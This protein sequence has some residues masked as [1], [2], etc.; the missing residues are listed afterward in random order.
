M[1]EE[2]EKRSGSR[3][4]GRPTGSS[5]GGASRGSG[6][7]A[8]GPRWVDAVALLAALGLHA[9][10]PLAPTPRAVEREPPRA[11]APELELELDVDLGSNDQRRAEPDMAEATKLEAAKARPLM[12][13]LEPPKPEV[14]KPEAPKPEP[15]PEPSKREA[16]SANVEQ[17][18]SAEAEA[19]KLAA[20]DD[21]AP[22]L[23]TLPSDDARD[24]DVAPPLPT[25]PRAAPEPA[26]PTLARSEPARV[27]PPEPPRAAPP[28]PPPPARAEPPRAVPAALTPPRAPAP[29]P[30][31]AAE[32]AP[33]PASPPAPPPPP[34][35]PAPP[36]AP[37]PPPPAPPPSPAPTPAAPPGP[38]AARL[39][40]GPA[41]APGVSPGASTAP[42]PEGPSRPGPGPSDGPTRPDGGFSPLAPLPVPGLGGPLWGLPGVLPS[43]RPPPAPTEPT[44]R[45]VDP[46]AATKALGSTLS[47]RDG[48][49]GLDVPGASVAASALTDAVRGSDL[50][51]E[52][53]AT[54][55]VK[56]DASGRVESIKVLGTTAGDAQ[57]WAAVVASAKA[58][59]EGRAL[60]MGPR[61]EAATVVVKVESSMR[62]PAGSR[63]AGVVQPVCANE[64]IEQIEALLKTP[65]AVAG[66]GRG[67]DETGTNPAGPTA[68]A[69][70]RAEE[71]K[72]KF[73]I[74]IGVR[75][76]GDLSNIG[77]RASKVVKNDVSI[78][79]AGEVALPE[80][81]V[82]PVDT[83]PRWLP[84]DPTKTRPDLPGKKPWWQKKKKKKK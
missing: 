13:K 35:S 65:N 77:A 33:S 1:P 37:P 48:K 10:L 4:S 66:F 7:A 53:R 72:R 30:P 5:R 22:P 23:P 47:K 40:G 19:R 21:V 34:A 20:R 73:C 28:P 50:P 51:P 56:L 32:P 26:R 9:L 82:L 43:Q 81:A 31:P 2:A 25:V 76:A 75:G 68:E 36:A 52:A 84:A 64:V 49:L 78:K 74:P 63:E 55:E 61:G 24:D 71:L 46:L 8:R 14:P 57:K 67:L 79:R 27:E 70:E 39:P 69:I 11:S 60:A 62:F 17:A 3:S 38:V 16:P 44:R 58:K 41:R 42:S 80:G 83:R 18:S 45:A 59:L 12:A 15:K 29:P 6:G 54:F